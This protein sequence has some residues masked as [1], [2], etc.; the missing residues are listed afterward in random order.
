MKEEEEGNIHSH[1]NL[2]GHLLLGIQMKDH[3]TLKDHPLIEG[4][5]ETQEDNSITILKILMSQCK[6]GN[7]QE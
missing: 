7:H 4:K 1:L 3:K 5:I 2:I 6:E